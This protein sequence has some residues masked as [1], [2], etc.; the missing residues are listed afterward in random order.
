MSGQLHLIATF[1]LQHEWWV[2]TDSQLIAIAFCCEFASWQYKAVQGLCVLLLWCNKIIVG[3]IWVR[4]LCVIEIELLA[5]PINCK[6]S[7]IIRIVSHQNYDLCVLCTVTPQPTP[8]YN[9]RLS[10]WINFWSRVRQVMSGQQN[11]IATFRLQHE[12][13][14]F[15]DSRRIAL[16]K[17]VKPMLSMI[18]EDKLNPWYMKIL[19]WINDTWRQRTNKWYPWYMN[20]WYMKTTTNPRSE[21]MIY[22]C[23]IY[24]DNKQIHWLH[25]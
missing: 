9:F 6:R 4:D 22:E 10:I 14:V 19:F 7:L 12:W 13:W 15:T 16:I 3:K 21:S 24:E 17:S 18:H 23:M 8:D 5:Q 25:W 11:L 20:P 1:R 2:F